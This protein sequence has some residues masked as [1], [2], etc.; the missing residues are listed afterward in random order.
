MFFSRL[1]TL[2]F[3]PF[4]V[5]H[6]NYAYLRF[7]GYMSREV[8]GKPL[9]ECLGLPIQAMS[10]PSITAL[11]NKLVHAAVREEEQDLF[12][13]CSVMISFIG[14]ESAA[15]DTKQV[16]EEE[17]A[18]ESSDGDDEPAI[19]VTHYGVD[20]DPLESAGGVTVGTCTGI[21]VRRAMVSPES[22]CFQGVLG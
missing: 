9:A 16:D 18:A 21:D 13:D 15:R 11:D 22:P 14:P 7:T 3:P 2:S 1:V 8:L 12:R 5:V 20:L 17:G 19:F 10:L 6:A 4:L